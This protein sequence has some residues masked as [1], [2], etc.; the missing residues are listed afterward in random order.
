MVRPKRSQ[1]HPDLRK[2]ITET[3]QE[4]IAEQLADSDID[5]FAGGG[6]KWLTQRSD[7]ANLFE[8]FATPEELAN[9]D[10]SVVEE[11]IR[12]AGF[13]KQKARKIIDTAR[14]IVEKHG[15]VVPDDIDELLALP[16]VGRKTANCVSLTIFRCALRKGNWLRSSARMVV[17]KRLW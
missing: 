16:G 1:Q 6:I 3:A 11:L 9:A 7:N 10:V 5:F 2:A 17:V 4:Q 14:V 15:S 13:Y 8:K 12:P